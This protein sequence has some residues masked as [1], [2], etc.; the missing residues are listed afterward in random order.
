MLDCTGLEL[1]RVLNVIAL[2]SEDTFDV[3]ED[4]NEGVD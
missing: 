2:D 3:V 4:N 1:L